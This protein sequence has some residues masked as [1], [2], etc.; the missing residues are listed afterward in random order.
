MPLGRLANAELRKAKMAAHE[1]FDPVWKTKRMKRGEAYAWLAK[2]LRVNKDGC[3]IGVFD[4][5]MCRRVVVV[6]KD[7]TGTEC[8][9]KEQ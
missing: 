8:Q 6:C 1:A 9:G 4:V 3:H 2:K 5:E 7:I